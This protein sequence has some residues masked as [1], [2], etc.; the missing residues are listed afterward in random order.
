M[1]ISVFVLIAV[2]TFC[3][4]KTRAQP[5]ST[6]DADQAA[7]K[8]AALDYIEGW[9][10]GDDERMERALHSELAKRIVRTNDKGQSRLNQRI[11]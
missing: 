7:I 1:K 3:V 2:L 11:Q 6:S 5:I 4:C 8:Q 10:G 9:Y